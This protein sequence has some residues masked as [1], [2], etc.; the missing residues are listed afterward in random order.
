MTKVW[1]WCAQP[2]SQFCLSIEVA[3]MGGEQFLI[4]W[5]M[6]AKLPA[7]RTLIEQYVS[8]ALS[9]QTH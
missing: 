6:P 4:R 9:R 1:Y 2:A 3:G 5:R 7:R 8:L